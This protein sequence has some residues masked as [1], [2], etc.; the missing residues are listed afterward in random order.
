MLDYLFLEK[1]LSN[2]VKDSNKPKCLIIHGFGG[3]IHEIEPIAKHLIDLDYDVVCPT[4]KG[5][6]T[7]RKDMREAI[8]ADWIESAECEFLR[9]KESG[10]EVLLI[11]FSM[12][13]LIAF[14]L[15]SKY[16]IKAIVTINTPIF[17]WNIAQVLHN[18]L[19]DVKNRNITNIN[20]YLQ[21]KQNS[22]ISSMKQFL[23]LLN[24]TKYKLEKVKCPLLIIQ[25]KD[26]DTTRIKS[27]D[28][29]YKH[30]SSTNKNI[31]CLNEGGHQILQSPMA[32]QVFMSVDDFLQTL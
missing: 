14:N 28:Y 31:K 27:V 32:E 18:L 2:T 8:Y 15:A 9:M 19:D 10:D 5:H 11:G 20:R 25:A 22:P 30:V 3:G 13:G 21:A 24:H 29:I 12:G 17:Y 26:D 16:N 6:S 1:F 4:L 7:T 23:L